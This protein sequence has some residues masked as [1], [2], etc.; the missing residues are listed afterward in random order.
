MSH[1]KKDDGTYEKAG[2]PA[3]KNDG[4]QFVYEDEIYN[5]ESLRDAK[6]S[7]F[8]KWKVTV[9][10]NTKPAG[11][12]GPGTDPKLSETAPVNPVDEP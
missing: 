6:R 10:D 7:Q 3:V 12:A 1:P 2:V 11:N 8:E 5:I 4:T 9:A